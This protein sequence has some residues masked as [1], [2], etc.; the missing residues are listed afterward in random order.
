M[1]AIEKLK[2]DMLYIVKSVSYIK[3][4]DSIVEQN[5]PTHKKSFKA[6]YFPYAKLYFRSNVEKLAPLLNFVRGV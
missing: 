2:S 4:I 3:H 5:F 1:K 6:C